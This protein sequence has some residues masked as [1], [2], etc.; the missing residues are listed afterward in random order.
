MRN[1]I[2]T[3]SLTRERKGIFLMA[4]KITGSAIRKARKEKGLSQKQLADGI[5][6]QATISLIENRNVCPN[7]NILNQIC[8]RLAINMTDVSFNPRYGEKLFSYIESD[9]RRHCYLQARERM[10]RVS[11]DKLESKLAEGKYYCYQGFAELYIDDDIEEA[12]YHFNWMLTKYPY[13]NLSFYQAWSNLGLGLAYQKLGK[14]ARAPKFIEESIRILEKIQSHKN[15][16]T[17]DDICAVIDLYIDIIATY[18]ELEKFDRALKLCAVVLKRLTSTNSIYKIDVVEELASR[19]LYANGQIVEATMRQFT[20]M[21]IA[22]LRGN[23]QL[24]EKIMTKNQKHLIELVKKE[25]SK[26]DG[27][28]TLIV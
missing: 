2:N 8:Q 17:N 7:I 5:C 26:N 25:L 22:D 9:M 15:R 23:H 6:T 24:F 14:T 4:T 11:F 3:I 20:A 1:K 27:H 13:E 18:V 16:Y 10:G 28:E 12:I 21:F 19:C